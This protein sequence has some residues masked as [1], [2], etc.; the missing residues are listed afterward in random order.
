MPYKDPIIRAQKKHEAYLRHLNDELKHNKEYYETNREKI[1]L[2]KADY[3]R[4]PNYMKNR[5]VYL[6]NKAK[7]DADLRKKLNTRAISNYRYSKEG[8]V[9]E[10]CGC[11]VYLQLHHND[12]NNPYDVQI[13]CICC[14]LKRHGGRASERLK[15]RIAELS[16]RLAKMLL[17]PARDNP[18]T[19]G[20]AGL[21]AVP[22]A[23]GP[24]RKLEEARGLGPL[25]KP[26][27][28]ECSRVVSDAGEPSAAEPA[29][30][31]SERKKEKGEKA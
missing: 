31:S 18:P 5:I 3:A 17:A 30:S 24:S 11:R 10:E 4:S 28:A 25:S 13:L 22:P 8:K 29:N 14:H 19:S 6:K 16:C 27:D 15:K 23:G 26:S 9:C 7:T 12:Y 2:Q 20:L 1:L 21:Q